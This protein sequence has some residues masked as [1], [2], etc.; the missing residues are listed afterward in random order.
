MTTQRK[1]GDEGM[2]DVALRPVEDSDLDALFAQMRDPE[3]ARMG[4]FTPEDPD[5]RAA[6]DA[7]TARVRNAPGI[8]PRAVTCD[9]QLVGTVASFITGGQTEVTYWIDRAWWGRGGAAPGGAPPLSLC[10]GRA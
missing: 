5:G 6:F 8:T 2:P 9:G 3:A 4:A 7:H 1:R 10:A